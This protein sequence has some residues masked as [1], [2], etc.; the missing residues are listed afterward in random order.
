L[1]K[2]VNELRRPFDGIELLCIS[3]RVSGVTLYSFFRSSASYRVRIALALKGL[4]YRT[5]SVP[6]RDQSHRKDSYRAVNPQ[7]RLPTLELDDG[8]KLIQ[9]L[10][11]IEYLD[12]LNP[13]PRVIPQEPLARARVQAVA[14]IIGSDIHPLNNIGVREILAA[15]FGASENQLD[16][17]TAYWIHEGFAAIEDLIEPGQYAFGD[18]ITLAD[19]CI[20]PQVYNARRYKVPLDRFPRIMAAEAAASRHPAFAA[21]APEA[22]PDAA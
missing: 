4:P 12:T 5:V 18:T 20:V 15:K 9:S 19:I 21:A 22:Q 2:A 16:E 17:W 11:I 13:E 7:M 3:R 6:M 14:Q 8:T 10:A 1:F